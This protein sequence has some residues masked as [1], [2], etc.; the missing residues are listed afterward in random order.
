MKASLRLK[1]RSLPELAGASANLLISP[2]S[3]T[4][5]AVIGK[6]ACAA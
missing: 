6:E 4:P 1:V 2:E 3:D 5:E